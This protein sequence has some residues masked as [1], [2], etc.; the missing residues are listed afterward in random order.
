VHPQSVPPGIDSR[1]I[2]LDKRIEFSSKINIDIRYFEN[3]ICRQPV[4]AACLLL[5]RRTTGRRA[6]I[7]SVPKSAA[8]RHVIANSIIGIGLYQGLEFLLQKS[9]GESA[10]HTKLLFSRVYNNWILLKHARVYE[11]L[12]GRDRSQNYECLRSF[13]LR[14][15][16]I[17]Q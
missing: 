8:L 11:F 13:L 7:E 14:H 17:A 1:Y 10:R 3:K 4:P 5:G 9:F 2:Q 15:S 12:I 16:G 6:Q